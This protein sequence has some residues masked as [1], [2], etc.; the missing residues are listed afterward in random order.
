MIAVLL[1]VET[2]A[3]G[4]LFMIEEADNNGHHAV[5]TMEVPTTDKDAEL[6]E[7]KE[8]IEISKEEFLQP[9]QGIVCP[10]CGKEFNDGDSVES[11]KGRLLHDICYGHR[12]KISGGSGE[13]D[14]TVNSPI[15]LH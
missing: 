5:S 11:D 4:E 15:V 8:W 9:F 14:T 3:F 10:E 13:L 2:Y 7:G 1:K 12:M 6:V